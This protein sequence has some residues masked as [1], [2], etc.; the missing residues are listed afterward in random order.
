M[1]TKKY[2][3]K[4]RNFKISEGLIYKTFL[5]IFVSAIFLLLYINQ[6]T[7][8][9]LMNNFSSIFSADVQ[10]YGLYVGQGDSS[11]IILPDKTSILIDTGTKTYAEN[12]CYQLETILKANG[13]EDIDYL[14]ITHANS[15]HYG[16]VTKVLGRFKVNNI[17]RPKI[18][19][20]TEFSSYTVSTDSQYIEAIEACLNEK[21]NMFFIT[22]STV[23]LNSGI[24]TFWTPTEDEYSNSNDYSPII[25]IESAGKTLMFTGDAST[26]GENE[27]LE[28]ADNID[29]EVDI[30]KVAHHGSSTSTSESFLEKISPKYALISAGYDNTYNFPTQEVVTRLLNAGVRAIYNTNDL[31][32]IGLGLFDNTIA[33]SH[34]FFFFDKP[35]YLV[36]Y[37][38]CVFA[39]WQI[40]FRPKHKFSVRKE[41]LKI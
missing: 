36:A 8:S 41:K 15:D 21:S 34:S 11:L 24:L 37:L 16:G 22:P 3:R 31:G 39:I 19:L 13:K 40:R 29:F 26:R 20:P 30:L 9:F 38:I 14:I 2:L 4:I 6:M 1:Q 33:V 5:I 35:F 10:V 27:F 28:V 7:I 25:T 32:T 18:A 17:F 12:L 23:N